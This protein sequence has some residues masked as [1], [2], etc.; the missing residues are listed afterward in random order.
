M[1]VLGWA[2]IGGAVLAYVFLAHYVTVQTAEV[3]SFAIALTAAPYVGFALI[4]A[5]RSS[6][7]YSMFALCVVVAT[8]LW[9]L[10]LPLVALMFS[11]EYAVRLR[12]LP[13]IKHVTIL[14]SVRMY[15]SSSRVSLPP[16]R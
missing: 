12:A 4:L 7:R 15:W 16:S 11:A 5:W 13:D 8:L 6:R 1:R 9:L 2:A 3:G 14:D 10:S